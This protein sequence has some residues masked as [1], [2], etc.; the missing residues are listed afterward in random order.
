MVVGPLLGSIV[1]CDETKGDGFRDGEIV[2][3]D[4]LSVGI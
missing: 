2:G 4:G 3:V 1:G